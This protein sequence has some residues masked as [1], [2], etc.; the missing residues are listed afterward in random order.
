MRGIAGGAA[1]RAGASAVGAEGNVET[2][3]AAMR[4][5]AELQAREWPEDYLAGAVE[6]LLLLETKRR[7]KQSRT[8][9]RRSC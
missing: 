3:A 2:I 9:P 5:E 7:G 6:W 4:A 8:V 1:V